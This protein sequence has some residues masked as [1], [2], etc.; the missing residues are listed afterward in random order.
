MVDQVP[1]LPARQGI[2]AGGGLV[3]DQQVRVVDQRA[4][5]AEL[6]LHAARQLAGRAVGKRRQPGAGEQAASAGRAPRRLAE[7]AAEEV[8][9]LGHRE[10]RVEVLAQSLRHVGDPRADRVAVTGM[11][12]SPPST[13]TRPA[14]IGARRE[15]G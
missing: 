9:V 13:S 1:E 4:A 3:E 15:Q 5:Q 14:W 7:Q 6:L 12:M 10:R 2:D 11:A 8:D